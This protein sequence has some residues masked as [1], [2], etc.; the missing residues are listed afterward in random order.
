M[1]IHVPAPLFD[2]LVDTDPRTREER[3]PRRTLDREELRAS[4]RRELERLLNTRSS[5]PAPEL[6]SRE[7]TTLEY[8]MPDFSS[9]SAAAPDD[10]ALL[11]ATVARV[12]SAFEPRLREVRVSVQRYEDPRQALWI[13]IEARLEVGEVSEPVSFP[14]VLGLKT[15]EARVGDG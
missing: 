3:R 13:T 6:R 12:V 9:Y 4:V 2:R 11:A 1:A 5:L 14:T 7:L 8:G 10:Q 15:G